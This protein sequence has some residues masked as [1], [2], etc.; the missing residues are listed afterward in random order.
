MP[1]A[2]LITAIGRVDRLGQ[3]RETHVFCYACEGEK[4]SNELHCFAIF[5]TLSNQ[6]RSRPRSSTEVLALDIVSTP[7]ALITIPLTPKQRK[8]PTRRAPTKTA[9]SELILRIQ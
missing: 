9:E 3:E 6:K 4:F 8:Y 2:V 1:I 7:K 5:D